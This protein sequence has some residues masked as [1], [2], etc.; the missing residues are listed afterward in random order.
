[1]L[2][3]QAQGILRKVKIRVPEF[4][5]FLSI[6]ERKHKSVMG[7]DIQ[8]RERH[9]RTAGMRRGPRHMSSRSRNSA[10]EGLQGALS[11]GAPKC[12]HRTP[13]W[14]EEDSEQRWGYWIKF[15]YFLF[16]THWAY[17]LCV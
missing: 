16:V 15:K 13:H 14:K 4:L 10:G 5:S 3:L 7:V 17:A 2:T 12:R 6:P 8:N 11:E 1:M 9:N